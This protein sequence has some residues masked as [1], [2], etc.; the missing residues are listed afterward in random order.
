M[1]AGAGCRLGSLGSKNLSCRMG[2]LRVERPFRGVCTFA[3]NCD[4]L[5][6]SRWSEEELVSCHLFADGWLGGGEEGS[7]DE[8]ADDRA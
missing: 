4:F 2:P 8:A 7:G 6:S 1:G 3:C 5:W